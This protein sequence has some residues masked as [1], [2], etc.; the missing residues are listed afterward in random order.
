MTTILD[1]TH[2]KVHFSTPMKVVRFKNPVTGMDSG[3]VRTAML[4]GK[5]LKESPIVNVA[6]KVE[7]SIGDDLLME[8]HL[9]DAAVLDLHV[10]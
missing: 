10:T 5:K 6:G 3:P 8:G 4:L 1:N 9:A 7:S 2:I